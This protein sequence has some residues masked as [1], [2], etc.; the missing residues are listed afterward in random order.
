MQNLLLRSIGNLD[1]TPR[2]YPVAGPRSAAPRL[3]LALAWPFRSPLIGDHQREDA[4]P[5]AVGHEAS[6]E[7]DMLAVAVGNVAAAGDCP[8]R[9]D[10][11]SVEGRGDANHRLRACPAAA[12]AG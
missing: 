3:G 5:P 9:V 6:M 10:A 8:R 7:R 1:V 4:K 12:G 2:Q 11:D